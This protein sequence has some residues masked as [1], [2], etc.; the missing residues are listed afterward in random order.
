MICSMTAFARADRHLE[1][2]SLAWEIKSVNHR[3]LEVSPRLPDTLRAL[4]NGARDKCRQALARGKVEITLRYQQIDSDVELELNEP[5]VKKLSDVSRRVGDLVQHSG[6]VNPMEILRYPGVLSSQELD[7]ELLQKEA[8]T[9]LDEALKALIDTR[10][11][12]GEQLGNLILDRLDGI[13]TQVEIV[14]AAIPRIKEAQRER[15]RKRIQDVVESP[16]PDRLEQEL[17]MQAQKMDVDEELDRLVT[18]V[19]EV[20]RIVKK[21]GHIG[22]RLDFLMQELNREA[23]TL[24]SK[25]VDSETTAAAVELKV[26]IEQMREQIQNIE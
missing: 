22:R 9:L 7:V 12:E 19:S 24:A 1:G 20:R 25:S 8:L 11:R 17:V 10:A 23:N 4:E 16:D 21:G 6:Q 26:L 2:F 3:Y 5:L 14:K 15:L 13:M 18:H